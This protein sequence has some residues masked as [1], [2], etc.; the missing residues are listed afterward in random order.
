M[1][2]IKKPKHA[3]ASPLMTTVVVGPRKEWSTRYRNRKEEE[4]IEKAMVRVDE[5]DGHTIVPNEIWEKIFAF[6][7][8]DNDLRSLTLVSKTL[9]S[10][11]NELLWHTPDFVK[12]HLSATEL[13]SLAHLPIRKLFTCNLNIH[14]KKS[15]VQEF[16]EVFKKMP[17]LKEVEVYCHNSY[18]KLPLETLRGIA[19]FITCLSTDGVLYKGPTH[20]DNNNNNNNSTPRDRWEQYRQ[21]ERRQHERHIQ[22]VK[23]LVKMDLP[24]LTSV[25][26][27]NNCLYGYGRDRYSVEDLKV[28]N[29]LPITEIWL[30]ALKCD[31]GTGYNSKSWSKVVEYLPEMKK[32]EG[33]FVDENMR[34]ANEKQI[35][36]FQEACKVKGVDVQ[37]CEEVQAY[38]EKERRWRKWRMN[39]Y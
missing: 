3:R 19:P 33:I 36:L 4:A 10:I 21:Q 13:E 32:L 30:S 15:K 39:Y 7:P 9:R 2:K 5:D 18:E 23:E 31:E 1:G 11:V 28:L 22:L 12:P 25:K 34:Y 37:V 29:V 16:Y 8:D 26:V 6:L 35:T 20:S 14:K 27:L 17:Y 38:W 24:N